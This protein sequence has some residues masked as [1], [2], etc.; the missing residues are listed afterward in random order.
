MFGGRKIVEH[1]PKRNGSSVVLACLRECVCQAR[2][3]A[4][5]H[6]HRKILALNKTGA[7]MLR[8]GFPLTAT[9]GLLLWHELGGPE[10][11]SSDLLGG[12]LTL[13]KLEELGCYGVRE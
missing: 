6:P 7:Y 2:E 3:T 1:E 13:M 11:T 8:I 12:S 9:S 4:N 10:S 5:F